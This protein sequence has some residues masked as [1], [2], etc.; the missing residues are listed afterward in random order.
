ML[1][2]SHIVAATKE[3]LIG[4]GST[5]PWHLP[6]DLAF[7]K[8]TTMGHVVIMGGKT[9][10]SMG[11]KPLP[12]RVNIVISRSQGN[13]NN[14]LFFAKSTYEALT[15]ALQFKE[16]HGEE[17]FIAGGGEIYRATTA[18]TEKVYYTEISGYDFKGSVYYPTEILKAFKLIEERPL[19]TSG[20]IKATI[21]TYSKF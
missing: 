20:K 19:S 18:V 17:I 10:R 9:F 11:S 4:D 16:S 14:N 12:G 2:I 1:K 5:M 8:A 7:F 21:K 15:V 3:G 6:E 13:D